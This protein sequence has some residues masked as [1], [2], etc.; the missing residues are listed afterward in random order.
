MSPALLRRWMRPRE[1]A[2]VVLATAT[3]AS[4]ALAV[5]ADAGEVPA[6]LEEDTLTARTTAVVPENE[7]RLSEEPDRIVLAAVRGA[8]EAHRARD[9][10]EPEPV[11]AAAPAVSSGSIW[12]AI[13]QCESSGQWDLN[14]G[15]YD[16]GLQFHP[17]TWSAYAPSDYPAY[18]YQ[19]TR[20]Q[21]IYV[22]ELV[23]AVQGWDAWPVCSE[24]VGVA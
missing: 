21:Q 15:M 16:G 10:A 13:A 17:D 9:A 14:V 24:V 1:F 3:V 23:L 12:D 4:G 18:A 6:P 19:A 22:A 7:P 11:V 8:G 5:E 2:T 20:E